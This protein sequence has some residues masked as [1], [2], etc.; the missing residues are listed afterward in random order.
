M[1]ILFEDQTYSPDLLEAWGLEPFMFTGRDGSDA[2]LPYVGYVYSSKINDSI[3][4]LPKV[5]LFKRT[6]LTES[7]SGFLHGYTGPST[8]IQHAIHTAKSSSAPPYRE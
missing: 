5:F 8:N 6:G 2:M 4:I 3:F 1:R 7:C